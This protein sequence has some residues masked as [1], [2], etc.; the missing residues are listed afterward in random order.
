MIAHQVGVAEKSTCQFHIESYH[1][2][3][4]AESAMRE[5]SSRLGGNFLYPSSLLRL[6]AGSPAAMDNFCIIRKEGRKKLYHAWCYILKLRLGLSYLYPF[7][8][9][10][11]SVD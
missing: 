10:L 6:P 2:G 9:V 3:R 11:F 7:P 4:S 1:K 5:E 8:T